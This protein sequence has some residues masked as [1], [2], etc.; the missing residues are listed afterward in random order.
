MDGGVIREDVMMEAEAECFT[1]RMEKG[2][3]TKV[4]TRN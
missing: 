2:P 1:L 3:Q 4:D